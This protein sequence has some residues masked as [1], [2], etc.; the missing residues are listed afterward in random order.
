[1][2]ILWSLKV[3]MNRY[4]HHANFEYTLYL[5]FF[6]P[7]WFSPTLPLKHD[8]SFKKNLI[9]HDVIQALRGGNLTHGNKT[10]P[11]GLDFIDGCF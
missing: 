8:L 4:F 1:M 5:D 10:R 9:L 6:L 3:R 7:L 2:L 11:L